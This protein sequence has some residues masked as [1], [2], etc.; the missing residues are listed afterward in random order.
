MNATGCVD[1]ST[2]A[3]L[4]EE[5]EHGRRADGLDRRK[6]RGQFVVQERAPRLQYSAVGTAP[7]P[8]SAL[9]ASPNRTGAAVAV[10]GAPGVPGAAVARHTARTAE[11]CAE[12]LWTEGSGRAHPALR[13]SLAL[14]RKA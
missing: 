13:C 6:L 9:L 10:C 5:V 2:R 1:L 3:R 12:E 14:R 8:R 11:R 4:V 7:R